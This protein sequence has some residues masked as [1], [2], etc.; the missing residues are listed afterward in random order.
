MKKKQTV[1]CSQLQSQLQ[2]STTGFNRVQS[3]LV[4]MTGEQDKTHA[5]LDQALAHL[6]TAFAQL[7]DARTRHTVLRSQLAAQRQLYAK[8]DQLC[9]NLQINLFSSAQRNIE[10]SQATSNLQQAHEDVQVSCHMYYAP[11]S[12]MQSRAPAWLLVS[13]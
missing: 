7:N 10:I 4:S 6:D 13:P 9:T 5:Q 2:S 3:D 12:T 8:S 1:Q 11:L